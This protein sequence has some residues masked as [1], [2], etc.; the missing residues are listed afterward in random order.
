M[1]LSRLL[2]VPGVEYV[3]Q[4]IGADLCLLV[5]RH[6]QSAVL[7]GSHILN[8]PGILFKY[9]TFS[10]KWWEILKGSYFGVKPYIP[11]LRG[12]GGG[13]V[14]APAEKVPLLGSSWET[15]PGKLVSHKLSSFSRNLYFCLIFSL[16]TGKVWAALHEA[17]LHISNHL[18]K[19]L[20]TGMES[21]IVQLDFSAAFDRVS[22]SGLLFKLKSIG[23]GGSVLSICREF[24]SN[25][26]QRV[27]ID[28]ATSH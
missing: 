22:H 11:A 26:K 1:M 3:M 21:Y 17:L 13:L 27:L 19:F 12:P 25:R 6:R 10:H 4:I 2:L 14:V 5:L 16:L 28:D 20:D 18:Q 15:P 24:L 9:F 23:V 8:I 7:Q